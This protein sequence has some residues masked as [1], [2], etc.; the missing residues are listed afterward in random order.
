MD[1]IAADFSFDT[2]M[3]IFLL[4]FNLR[5]DVTVSLLALRL[6]ILP[7]FEPLS[8]MCFF[9]PAGLHLFPTITLASQ[10]R[11][12]GVIASFFVNR[13]HLPCRSCGPMG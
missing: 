6:T 8:P 13:I 7:S 11:V 1:D 4:D 2:P 12:G 5:S 9:G 3:S 10:D